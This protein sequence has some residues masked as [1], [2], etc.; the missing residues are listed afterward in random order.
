[1]TTT[2]EKTKDAIIAALKNSLLQGSNS[3]LYIVREGISSVI[4]GLT[5]KEETN[6][7]EV[8]LSADKTHLTVQDSDSIELRS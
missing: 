2:I 4:S 7:I 8:I 1:M 3:K 5:Y 6:V